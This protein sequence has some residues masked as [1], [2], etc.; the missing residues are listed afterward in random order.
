MKTLLIPSFADDAKIYRNIKSHDDCKLVQYAISGLQSWSL[1]WLLSLNTQKCRVVS[2]GRSVDKSI[3][4]TLLDYNNQE[5]ALERKD[6]VKD[7]GVW[8]DEK[9]LFR[10]HMHDKI[11][12]A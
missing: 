9:L 10:E 5:I 6:T 4:Y 2:Y 1:K 3:T 7:L 12:K 8:F 11:S